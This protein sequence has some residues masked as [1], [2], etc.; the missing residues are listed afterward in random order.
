MRYVWHTESKEPFV[1][2]TDDCP[3]LMGVVGHTVYYLCYEPDDETCLT[4]QLL[5]TFP[6]R[7]QTTVV[8][9]DRC[10][11]DSNTL[12]RLGIVFKQVPREIVRM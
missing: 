9:A 4:P 7:E 11:I 2:C 8:Y 1:D 6:R 10:L 5:S 12:E 3:Y